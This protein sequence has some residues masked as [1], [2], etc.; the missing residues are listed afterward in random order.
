MN[1]R[2]HT[3]AAILGCINK[4]NNNSS[5]KEEMKREKELNLKEPLY[6]VKINFDEASTEWHANKRRIGH[7]Y[8]YICREPLSN[9]NNKECGKKCYQSGT[10][11]FIHRKRNQTK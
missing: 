8:I 10:T 11:C 6:T 4:I 7:E 5:S 3:K 1:T 9:T 2:S